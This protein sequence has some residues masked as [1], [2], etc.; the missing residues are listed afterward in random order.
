[1][2]Y[3]ETKK[4]MYRDPGMWHALMEKLSGALVSYLNAQIAAGVDAVQIFDSWVGCLSPS[5][6]E[7]FVKPHVRSIFASLDRSVPSIHFGTG[8]VS[9]YPHMKDAGGDVIGVDW[10]VDL[11][12]VW[13][14]LGPDVAVMGNLDPAAILA[15][16]EVMYKMVDRVLEAAQGRNGHIFNLGHGIMPEAS[17]AQARALVDYVHARSE[18]LRRG[19]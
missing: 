11:G 19:A 5:D 16:R 4:L 14:T 1:K 18:A 17:P 8:N 6:Y 2:N 15:P 9:L 12:D 7:Q 3:Y 13:D 10:R